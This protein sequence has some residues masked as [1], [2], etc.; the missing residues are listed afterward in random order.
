MDQ[1]CSKFRVRVRL[2][3]TQFSV[4]EIVISCNVTLAGCTLLCFCSGALLCLYGGTSVERSQGALELIAFA[5]SHQSL[6]I[7]VAVD[8]PALHTAE[9]PACLLMAAPGYTYL[10]FTSFTFFY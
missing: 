9:F 5:S 7:T 2:L 1:K 6:V 10:L 3:N 4:F 8:S